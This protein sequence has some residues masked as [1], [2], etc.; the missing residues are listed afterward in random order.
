M[1]FD[2]GWKG[3]SSFSSY[4]QMLKEVVLKKQKFMQN[5]SR[6]TLGSRTSIVIGSQRFVVTTWVVDYLAR[7]IGSILAASPKKEFL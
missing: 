1:N 5:F 6:F 2:L 7:N 3:R 4:L